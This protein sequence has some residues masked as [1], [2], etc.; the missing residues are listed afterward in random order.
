M[1]YHAFLPRRAAA[2]CLAFLSL[3]VATFAGD[4]S[5]TWTCTVTSP[6]E[7]EIE[8]TL[9]LKHTDG[10]VTGTMKGRQGE[11]TLRNGTF[12]GD[13]LR[14]TVERKVRRRTVTTTYQG[15]LEGDTLRGTVEVQAGR[16][17]MTLPWTATRA[18]EQPAGAP[19]ASGD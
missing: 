18:P 7:R 10:R 8:T 9:Q 19:P 2:L 5:G 17:D 12:S 3:A 11:H 1:P 15:K 14:F 4:P 16:K 13:T 6:K